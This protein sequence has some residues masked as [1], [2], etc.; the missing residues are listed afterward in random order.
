[1]VLELQSGFAGSRGDR[2]DP[3]VVEVAAS[4]EDDLGD[5]GGLG[6]L[7]DELA[8]L[9]GGVLVAR[10]RAAQVGLGGGRGR[11]GA[12]VAVVDHLGGDVL[13]GAEH[14]EAGALGGALHLLPHPAVP[15]DPCF[16]LVLCADGH[17]VPLLARLPGLLGDVLPEVPDA[18]A[19][20]GLG[21]AD[22]AD[23]G[24]HLADGLLVDAP[25]DDAVR[26]WASRR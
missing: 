26:A 9:G 10:G 21:L 17:E 18:L 7:G 23:V 13:V 20:V 6:P 11:E 22:L 1:M 2:R 8:D 5:A 4:I 14:G 25:N 3:P 16:S 24:G 19:L 12:P 15:P